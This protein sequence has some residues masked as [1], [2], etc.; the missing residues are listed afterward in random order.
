M[1]HHVCFFFSS[2]FPDLHARICKTYLE[3]LS[4]DKSLVTIYGGIVG[5]GALG[6]TVVRALLLNKLEGFKTVLENEEREILALSNNDN[7]EVEEHQKKRTKALLQEKQLAVSKCK[8]AIQ[9]TLGRL[10]TIY[11]LCNE[12]G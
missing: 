9:S 2:V 8:E 4:P 12:C 5:I 7:M 3:A 11:Q 10:Q 1:C 6:H